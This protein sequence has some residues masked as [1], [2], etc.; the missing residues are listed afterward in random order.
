MYSWYSS[1]VDIVMWPEVSIDTCAYQ[2]S[3]IIEH[4]VAFI[5]A[6]SEEVVAPKFHFYYIILNKLKRLAL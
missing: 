3:L 4:H 6:Y 5:K 2:K 1:I